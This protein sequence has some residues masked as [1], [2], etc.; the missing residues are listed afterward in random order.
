M[1]VGTSDLSLNRD[2]LRQMDNYTQREVYAKIVSLTWDEYA[3]EEITGN[4]VSGTINVDG[5]STTRRTCSLSILADQN[6]QFTQV[7]W[8][9]NT[10]F[11]VLIGL[12]NFIDDSLPDIIWFQ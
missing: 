5:S 6:A 4:I 10:K 1:F 9:L 12:K 2:F 7:E 3:I 11:A 8:G